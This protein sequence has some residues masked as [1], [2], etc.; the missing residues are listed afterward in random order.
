MADVR[1]C[2]LN[3]SF[4]ISWSRTLQTPMLFFSK[5]SQCMAILK[6]LILAVVW[7]SL[8]QWPE[9]SV[10]RLY[11]AIQPK[12]EKMLSVIFLNSCM[13][14]AIEIFVW[15]IGCFYIDFWSSESWR[16]TQIKWK[17]FLLPTSKKKQPVKSQDCSQVC[18]R[19]KSC[20]IWR[21][22]KCVRLWDMAGQRLFAR[23][24]LVDGG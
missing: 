5:G 7:S 14:F 22:L 6:F 1:G 21:I 2:S 12:T 16:Q 9:L 24:S 13:A 15:N 19:T 11:R 17:Q 20:F 8:L 18:W 23:H 4:Q 3:L 10:K